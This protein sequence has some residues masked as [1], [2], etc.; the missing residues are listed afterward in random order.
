[1]RCDSL[2]RCGLPLSLFAAAAATASRT[3]ADPPV[4][5]DP[6]AGIFDMGKPGSTGTSPAAT[7]PTATRPA[8]APPT[9]PPDPVPATPATDPSPARPAPPAGDGRQAVPS[10]A[11]RAAAARAAADAYGSQIAA[12]V[13]ADARLDLAGKL[14]ATAVDEPGPANVFV[15]L[16]LARDTA[17]GAGDL[18]VATVAVDRQAARFTVDPAPLKAAAAAVVL[19]APTAATPTAAADRRFTLLRVA[20][21]SE[22]LALA[23]RG[24]LAGPLDAAL[25]AAAGDLHDPALASQVRAATAAH[26]AQAAAV[27][28]VVKQRAVLA[29]RPTD[30]AANEAVGRYECLVSDDWAAGVPHLAA[31]ADP[32]LRAAA[33]AELA[34]GSAGPG[35][36][37][38]GVDVGDAWRAAAKAAVGPARAKLLARAAHWYATAAAGSTG[39]A[40]AKA[41]SRQRELAAATPPASA[42]DATVGPPRGGRPARPGRPRAGRARRDL[43]GGRGRPRLR[44]RPRLPPGAAL[45]P[46][47]RVR[48][49]GDVHP[50]QRQR[51]AWT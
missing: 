11:D 50:H 12:A 33:A 30:P 15:L 21:L 47:G 51:R 13:S 48:P 3:S 28:A 39:L 26:V 4:P 16:D 20:T 1:M 42:T 8:D 43:G 41:E 37:D 5:N 32:L 10:A 2:R 45:P 24:D 14:L 29:T 18:R 6:G 40:K 49:A 23:G 36:A 25:L 27:A 46:A 22:S 17:A 35:S 44:R 38:A 34:H 7:R 19:R 9:P 31:G